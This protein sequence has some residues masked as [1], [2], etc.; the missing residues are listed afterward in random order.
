MAWSLLSDYT[1]W[2]VNSQDLPIS[3]PLVQGFQVLTTV[4]DF[5][6]VLG[7]GYVCLGA[8]LEARGCPQCQSLLSTLFEAG[9][10]S[11]FDAV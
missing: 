6:C 8:G 3:I 2:S 9:A 10:L 1:D 5:V 7:G 4:P 11:L